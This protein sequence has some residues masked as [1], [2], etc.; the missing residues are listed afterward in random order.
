MSGKIYFENKLEAVMFLEIKRDR[1]RKLFNVEVSGEVYLPIKSDKLLDRVKDVQ[2]S[3]EIPVASFVEGMFYVLGIDDQFKYKDIYKK[4]LDSLSSSI[5]FIKSVIFEKV[6]KEDFEEAY[7][8]LKGLIQLE[9]N[10]ENINRLILLANNIKLKDKN[11]KDEFLEVI[12]KAKSFENNALPYLY[13]AILKREAEDFQGALNSINMHLSKGGERTIEVTE[14]IHS[15]KN[16]VNYEVGK[17]LLYEDAGEALKL[18]LPLLDEYGDNAPLYYFIAVGYRILENHEKAIYYLNEALAIDDALVEVVNELG[19]N[20]ASLGDYDKAIGY[21]RKAFEAT[22]SIEI[23]T[24]LVMCYLNS[25]NLEQA[26]N[27]LEIAEKLDKNDE[28]VL[29]LKK[30]LV[31]EE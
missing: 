4:I 20:Y 14:F 5:A 19:I 13:E 16:I 28:I 15:L 8:L 1:I 26:R 3:E 30:I 31:A 11:F 21:L 22:K 6:K 12:D 25:G 29:E 2:K 10:E 7:I 9:F 24:N 17:E 23:C 27:H 18:L